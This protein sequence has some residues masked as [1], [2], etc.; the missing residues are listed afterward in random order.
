MSR[1]LIRK[2][3]I[4]W[5]WVI[6]VRVWATQY[7]INKFISYRAGAPIGNGGSL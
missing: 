7:I 2:N 4:F 3:T 5:W 6:P 1:S